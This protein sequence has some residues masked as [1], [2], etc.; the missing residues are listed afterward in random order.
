MT[1]EALQLSRRYQ[2]RKLQL[3]ETDFNPDSAFLVRPP[4]SKRFS[5]V[6]IDKAC[7]RTQLFSFSYGEQPLG[8]FLVSE[9]PNRDRFITLQSQLSP[10]VDS[11]LYTAALLTITHHFFMHENYHRIEIRQRTQQPAALFP[12]VLEG[13][14]PATR[15]QE[16]I[17]IYS[18]LQVEY[19]KQSERKGRDTT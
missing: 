12:F 19:L 15:D 6:Y 11:G 8:E 13:N 2:Q 14:F 16:A 18:L 1:I 3:T 10:E 7:Q 5:V 9:Y 17:L 4:G